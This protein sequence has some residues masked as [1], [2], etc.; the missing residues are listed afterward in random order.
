MGGTGD[1][2][3]LPSG[4]GSSSA[5]SSSPLSP[6]SVTSFNL[7]RDTDTKLVSEMHKLCRKSP[8][9]PKKFNGSSAYNR[10]Q[11]AGSGGGASSGG[12]GDESPKK[13]S[14]LTSIGNK[15]K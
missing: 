1:L 8:F 7:N 6:P 3:R 4:S 10:Y 13:E 11:T 2:E 15:N 14:V 9:M 5:T 12:G